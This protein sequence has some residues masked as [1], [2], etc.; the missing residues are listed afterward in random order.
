MKIEKRRQETNSNVK[1]NTTAVQAAGLELHRAI[2][3]AHSPSAQS[4]MNDDIRL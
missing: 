4:T 2:G 3:L 1:A